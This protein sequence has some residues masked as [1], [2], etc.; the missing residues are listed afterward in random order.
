MK[1]LVVLGDH[2]NEYIVMLFLSDISL[3]SLLPFL[4]HAQL[5]IIAF[6]SLHCHNDT[7]M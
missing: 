1:C 2:A 5:T 7:I 4:Y 6:M 3:L